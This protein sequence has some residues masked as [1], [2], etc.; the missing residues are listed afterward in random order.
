MF[1]TPYARYVEVAFAT[2]AQAKQQM[3]ACVSAV[4]KVLCEPEGVWTIVPTTEL[5]DVLH[6]VKQL[7][8]D[9]LMEVASVVDS[10]LRPRGSQAVNSRLEE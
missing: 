9:S 5:E 4:A 3:Q 2:D 6:A 1:V 10:I 8:R 7:S